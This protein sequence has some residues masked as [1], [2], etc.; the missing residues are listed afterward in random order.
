M[1]LQTPEE[2]RQEVLRE[3][4]GAKIII[5]GFMCKEIDKNLTQVI[6]SSKKP[7][8]NLK[9]KR[10]GSIERLRSIEGI[11][12]SAPDILLNKS[13]EEDNGISDEK[14]FTLAISSHYLSKIKD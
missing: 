7:Q 2:F 8:T 10:K 13:D 4:E 12:F 9:N 3:T 6:A 1:D 5:N 11:N 14:A